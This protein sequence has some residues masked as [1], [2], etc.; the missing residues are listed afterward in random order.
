MSWTPIAERFPTFP[1]ILAGPILRRTE[2]QAVTVW[3]ALKK[4]QTVT[5]RIYAQGEDGNLNEQFAGTRRTVRL[6]DHLYLV[7]VTAR[8]RY[9]GEQLAW[10]ALYYY[11][12][13]FQTD[14]SSDDHVLVTAA[15]LSTPGILNIDPSLADPLKQLVYPG[16]P[17][18]S[19]VLP[20]EDLNQL[21]IIHGSCRKPH[22]IGKE[23]LSA[24]DLILEDAV[25]NG[26]H[27][28]QQLFLTGDQIYA[29]DVAESLLFALTDAGNFLLTGNKEEVLPLV[30]VPARMLAPG[31]RT[32]PVRNVAMCTTDMPENHLLAL[33]E[34]YAMYLFAWSDVLW[35]DDLPIP[36]Y[37]HAQ[38]PSAQQ[39][40]MEQEYIHKTEQLHEFRSTLAQVRRALAN[41][42]TYMI[43]DDH[44][45][46][47]DWFLDGK[48]CQ[49]VLGS[50]LGRRIVRNGL[51]AYALFQAWGNTPDQFDEPHGTALLDAVNAWRGDE[52]DRQATDIGKLVGLPASFAGSGELQRSEQALRWNYT[53]SGPH[54]HVIVL[55]T[56]TQRIY[57]TPDAFPGLL[58]PRAIAA[59]VV[60]AAHEDAEITLMVS[61]T[62][63]LG[64]G[65]VEAIQFWSRMLSKEN[66]TVDPEAWTLE[67]FTF[68][69]FLKAISAMKRVVILSGDVHYAFGS[70]LKYWDRHSKTTAK[71]V[72]YTSSPFRN[73]G[74]SSEIAALAMG[75]P[76]IFNLL[77]RG[78]MPAVDFFAWDMLT[79]ST[80]VLHKILEMVRSR[81]YELWWSIPRLIDL[82]RS[83]HALVLPAQGWPQGAF[84]TLPPDRSYQLHYLHNM[85]YQVNVHK[86]PSDTKE[87]RIVEVNRALAAQ[88]T[89]VL[90]QLLSP[91]SLRERAHALIGKVARGAQLL[92][93]EAE[94]LVRGLERDRAILA[95][96]LFHRQEWLSHWQAGMLI[97]GYANIGEIGFQWT[98]TKKEAIQRL[99]WSHPQDPTRVI[100]A[101]EY[102]DTLDLPA[103]DE[104]PPLP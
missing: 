2:P 3:L 82:W 12:L 72:N 64:I 18:P 15:H 21:R 65:L 8:A 90:Q 26:V 39:Q 73:E 38:H 11:D 58:S 33:A 14:S 99:W 102:R 1:L 80:Q 42:A 27:R 63:V 45:V 66:N 51:L 23:M 86:S 100:P 36:E 98:L 7:A 75:Y 17:L 50:E 43:C 46:T 57:L 55:D 78:E 32:N 5:L 54:Y 94:L 71:I 61:A 4:S 28:P 81:G 41:I 88:E 59:Q 74:N 84:D 67:R 48:W 49:H 30:N 83:P 25:Q 70:S 62:P 93:H 52:S 6:G 92:E 77:K 40:Q 31:Q 91:E 37:S 29:D 104:A 16:H 44:D 85:Y 68:Q 13:F 56:R 79:D 96:V 97:V 95:D 53:F 89:I 47:D 22:G 76:E 9:S 35:P 34:Y 103:L 10:G 60:A 19:F 69:N 101:A 87:A 24:L 20:S